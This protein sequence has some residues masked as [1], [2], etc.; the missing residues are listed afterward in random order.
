M[1]GV[2]TKPRLSRQPGPDA[3]SERGVRVERG[4]HMLKPRLEEDRA[5]DGPAFTHP[6]SGQAQRRES[7]GA[8]VTGLFGEQQ[9][10][11][12]DFTLR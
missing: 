6:Q 11:T 7:P 9:V 4:Q 12:I 2:K 8:D 5:G 1:G 3:Q 10:A